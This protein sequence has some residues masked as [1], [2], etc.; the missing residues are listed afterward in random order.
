MSETLCNTEC[1]LRD[2]G[3]G[4]WCSAA[5]QF[6]MQQGKEAG[7]SRQDDAGTRPNLE[8]PRVIS[9][10]TLVGGEDREARYTSPQ[11][12]KG[13]PKRQGAQMM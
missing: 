10:P 4:R 5:L 2:A 8:F 6:E 9:L 1:R 7:R 3:V 12:Q 13:Q 11:V